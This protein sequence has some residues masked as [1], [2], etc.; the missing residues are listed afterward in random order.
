MTV[1][2]PSPVVESCRDDRLRE[3]RGVEAEQARRRRR[4]DAASPDGALAALALRDGVAVLACA[5]FCNVRRMQKCCAADDA[6][7]ARPSQQP[8]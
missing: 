2:L 4:L 1:A 8:R 5:D 7:G 6:A 3:R